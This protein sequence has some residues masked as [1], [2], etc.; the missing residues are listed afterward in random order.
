MILQRAVI[1]LVAVTAL[2]YAGDYAWARYKSSG[3]NS[4]VGLGSVQI[5]R[6]WEIPRKDGRVEFSWDPPEAE[7]CVHSL[8]PHFGYVP[9]WYAVRHTTIHAA[10]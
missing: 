3:A 1:V 2:L 7:T 4:S 10:Q 5:R 8:F 6:V 9:C